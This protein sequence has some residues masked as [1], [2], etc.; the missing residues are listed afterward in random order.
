MP[1]VHRSAAGVFGRHQAQVGHEFL[2]VVKAAQI[3]HFGYHGGRHDKRHP[4]QGLVGGDE[5]PSAPLGDEFPDLL[6]EALHP[7]A[8]LAHRVQVFLE[9][10][11]L[12]R[13][14]HDLL[15]QPA[16]VAPAPGGLAGI[17]AA[18]AQQQGAGALL[19]PAL[20]ADGVLPGPAQV[21][22][23]LVVCVRP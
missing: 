2:G 17:T 13:V 5:G 18:V 23:G 10:D 6:G 22:H 19:G 7:G 9:D 4:A 12:G 3:P 14:L 20:H 15:Q 1:P 21:P 16:P 8:G 11:L